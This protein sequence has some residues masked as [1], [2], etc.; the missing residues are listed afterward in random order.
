MDTVIIILFFITITVILIMC[1]FTLEQFVVNPNPPTGKAI[2]N[3]IEKMT[4]PSNLISNI[5]TATITSLPLSQYAIKGAYNAANSGTIVSTDAIKYVI[6]RGCRFLD[7]EVYIDGT[8]SPMAIVAYSTAIITPN[9][10]TTTVKLDS[11]NTLALDDVFSTIIGTAFNATGAPNY[12]DPIFIHLRLKTGGASLM[13][14]VNSARIL[15]PKLYNPNDDSNANYKNG[16]LILNANT[17]LS[18]IMGKVILVINGINGLGGIDTKLLNNLINIV[19]NSSQW[20]TYR[21]RD[22]E[23]MMPQLPIINIK[24]ISNDIEPSTNVTDLSLV[25]PAYNSDT[26]VPPPFSIFAEY[27]IQTLLVPFYSYMNNAVI[28][29]EQLFNTCNGGIVPFSIMISYSNDL[30][31]AQTSGSTSSIVQKIER[32]F[33]ITDAAAK[34]KTKPVA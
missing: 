8:D 3:E 33:G 4:L 21:Y 12:G 22:I 6:G 5:K 28:Q 14:I 16:P 26:V 2:T 30:L 11:A 1:F 24:G 19:S 15:T 32:N 18:E 25:M 23:N 9:T 7:F 13:P 20:K 31:D 17:L 27:G 29:Y 10:D 34:P